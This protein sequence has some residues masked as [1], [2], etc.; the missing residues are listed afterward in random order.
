MRRER[1]RCCSEIRDLQQQLS[2]MHDELDEVK[3]VE[4]GERQNIMK[5]RQL[6]LPL[7]FSP[8]LS[9]YL[10]YL[11]LSLSFSILP[12]F[13]SIL[14][15]SLFTSPSLSLS[16]SLLP[17]SLSPS[18]LPLLSCLHLFCLCHPLPLSLLLPGSLSQDLV[19]L[20]LEFQEVL[21]SQE[22]QED[23]LRRKERELTAL[24]GALEE[25]ITAHAEE[26]T[27]LKETRER[28]VQQMQRASEEARRV[29][30]EKGGG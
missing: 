22:A 19:S 28:E 24:R 14:P 27:T 20:K 3:E 8:S 29:R 6:R 25:E 21:T 30:E 16:F 18:L 17:L 11:Y 10:F 2:E 13:V 4:A 9:L 1:E 7:F 26:V 15:L 5:V 23:A 12:L